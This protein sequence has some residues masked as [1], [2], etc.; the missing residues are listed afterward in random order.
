MPSAKDR[1]DGALVFL[2]ACCL[3]NILAAGCARELLAASRYRFGVA[4]YVVDHKVLETAPLLEE[5]LLQVFDVS[6]AREERELV[7]FAM[8]LD[9][10]EA[11]TGALAIVRDARVATDDEKAIRV[12]RSAW[13]RKRRQA[14]SREPIHPRSC[15]WI[16]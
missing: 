10:G 1:G 3:I 2:D 15:G 5:G 11:H 13:E 6:S 8:E 4:R 12:L 7:R 14:G 16:G 9:D